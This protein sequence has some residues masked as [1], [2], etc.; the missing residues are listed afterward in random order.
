MGCS[1][2]RTSRLFSL[3]FLALALPLQTFPCLILKIA[4]GNSVLAGN[5]EDID[6]PLSKI[7]FE[8]PE[9]GKY[10]ITYFGYTANYP[11]GGMNDQ[12]LFFDGVAG[13]KT[14]WKASPQR[15]DYEGILFRKIM[16]ECATVEEAIAIFDKY[17]FSA[18]QSARI[19]LADRSGASAIVGWIDG[20][21]K[22]I[23]DTGNFQAV[24]FKEETALAMLKALKDGQKTLGADDVKAI[25]EACHQEGRYPTQY[26][27]ICDLKNNVVYMYLFHDYSAVVEF[28]ANEEY[29]KGKHDY[30]LL[31][32]FPNNAKAGE[33]RKIYGQT[34]LD[35]FDKINRTV[36]GTQAPW[37]RRDLSRLGLRLLDFQEYRKAIEVLKLTA[38][39]YPDWT[40]YEDLAFGY[41]MAR[42]I[43]LAIESYK[44]VLA[45]DP[46]NEGA[47]RSIKKLSSRQ[48]EFPKLIGPYLGQK[49]PGMTPIKFPFDDMPGEYKLHSAPVFTPDGK[50]IYFS[51]MDFSVRYSERI[52]VMKMIDNQWT[53]PQ[54]ASFS[55]NYF[56]GS[57]SLSRDGK[58][59]FFS[60]ARKKDGSG[61]NEAKERYIWYVRREGNDWS[62]PK[63]LNDPTLVVGNGSD[64]SESGNLF[65]NSRDIFQIKFPPNKNESPQ[66]LSDAVN[67]GDTELHP[68]IAPDERFLVFYS[69]RSPRLGLRGGDLYISFKDKEGKWSQ[70]K[71]LGEQFNKGHLSTSFP[72]LSPDGKYFFFLK[73]VSIPW[74]CDVYWVSVDALDALKDKR[75]F[76][77]WRFSS[78]SDRHRKGGEH[79][80]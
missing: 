69:S 78:C 49:P 55:G 9:K 22:S 19:F 40:S 33:A 57:P 46:G 56:E 8:P 28:D 30:P 47:A 35:S 72:R 16:E 44:K 61:M 59:L 32:F 66:K 60:S 54:V 48:S 7:W 67:S 4:H 6:N 42:E 25:L 3:I 51:A 74:K 41:E 70:A 50:E 27:N 71:N 21:L 5:N 12:G 14:D 73:L 38:A 20:E 36:G 13:Y 10:G 15:L 63:P 80:L 52:F 79:S 31:A 2:I 64:I 1:R 45:L 29:R 53:P 34:L 43:D 75:L 23:R 62:L 37:R 24:G 18:F 26:S 17:N 68:C 65:F 58:Y 11:Q 77:H 76:R 39:R